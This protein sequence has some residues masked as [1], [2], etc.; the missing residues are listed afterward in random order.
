M[1]KK[2][3]FAGGCFW[4]M[5]KPF[6]QYD[7]VIK[8]VSG[9]T[10]GHVE[11]PTYE[12]VCSD[13]TGHVEAIQIIY[14][15][16][17]ISYNE[18]LDIYWRQIDPTDAFGQ[19]HDRGHSYK[20][21]IFYHDEEQKRLAEESKKKLEESGIFEEKIVTQILEAKEFYEAEDYHQDYYKKNPNHYYRYFV[22]SGRYIFTKE[23]WD[24][25]NYNREKLKEILT[26]IQ[27]E[28]TQN[29]MT[30]PPFDNEY[31][32]NK[33][34]GIYV[35]VV[36]GEVLF[37]SKDKFDSGCGWPSFTKPVDNNSVYEKNDFT[38]GMVRTEVR[39]TNANSHLG[40]VFE[41]GPKEK[42][43]LRYCINSASLKFIPKEKMKE[44]GYEKYL[45]LL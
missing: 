32:D 39:S 7:G 38:H 16:N 37:T 6:D 43:G 31:H 14:D 40:H 1:V 17:V 9:Y 26:P 13:T 36:S 18:L 21:A 22:G 10:G 25:N 3:T 19:F 5:V 23:Y 41:D 44:E 2:A 8:V 45:E 12:E 35:D 27:F 24:K 20:S 29:D 15:D 33:E 42:G 28:V 4:C 30:E 34:E 11:N